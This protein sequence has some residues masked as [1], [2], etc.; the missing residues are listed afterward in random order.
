M[1]LRKMLSQDLDA[2]TGIEGAVTEFPWPRTQ[3]SD[4]LTGKDSCSVL[5]VDEQVCGFSIFS[6]VLDESTL[7]N[8]AVSPSM[9]GR[10]LGRKILQ[11]GL[12]HQKKQG[13]AK[14]FLEVRISNKAAQAL[15]YS[16]GFIN[17]GERKNYY[18][19]SGGR[20]TALVMCKDFSASPIA[21]V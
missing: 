19:A 13:I 2:V 20:E 11:R 5:V 3:F 10:R 21:I 9:Q 14:C 18:P 15:Y 4:S 17:I 8:I 6:S 12:E 16:L 7:L 1:V